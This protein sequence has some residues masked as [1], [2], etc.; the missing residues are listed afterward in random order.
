MPLFLLSHREIRVTLVHSTRLNVELQLN[1]AFPKSAVLAIKSYHQ[2]YLPEVICV[3]YIY[4]NE[5]F[6]S[7]ILG[8]VTE[9]TSLKISIGHPSERTDINLG[10]VK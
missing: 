4:W 8:V 5:S 1:Q 10:W 7:K 6:G 9:N 3:S 2:R